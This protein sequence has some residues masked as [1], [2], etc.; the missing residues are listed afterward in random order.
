MGVKYLWDTNTAIYYLQQQLPHHAE[1]FIDSLL[2]GSPPCISAITEIEL[3]CWRAMTDKDHELLL[4]FIN[5]C[6]VIELEQAIKFKTAEI[7][8]VHKIKLP[9][10]IIAASAMVNSCTLITRNISDFKN[11]GGLFLKNPW[12]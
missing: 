7:R 8:K 3:L 12:E 9:D 6:V 10:A 5:D 4:S 1:Q 2:K 11:I